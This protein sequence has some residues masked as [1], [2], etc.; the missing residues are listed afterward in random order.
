MSPARD[1]STRPRRRALARGEA[2]LLGL[3]L[4]AFAAAAWSAGDAWAEH[5][6]ASARAAQ[7]RADTD[8]LRGRL[9][10]LQQGGGPDAGLGAQAALTG[11]APPERVIA[12]IAGL[13]PADVRLESVL[14]TY[15]RQLQLELRVAARNPASFDAFLE[16]LQRSPAFADV[17]PGDEDRTGSMQAVIRARY[18]PAGP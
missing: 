12:E 3:G 16:R 1:F 8:A 14:M 18:A 7:A 13:L 6:A 4:L 2:G 15:G 5:R 9:G 17:L 11:E 10:A